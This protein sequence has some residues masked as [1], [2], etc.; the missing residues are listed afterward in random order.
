MQSVSGLE[1]FLTIS[2]QEYGSLTGRESSDVW[3]DHTPNNIDYMIPLAKIF[4]NAKFIHLIR[5]GRGVAASVIELPWGPN[6]ITAAADW[7]I[8]RLAVGLAA[9]QYFGP[10][11]VLRVKYEDLILNTT[12]TL[13]VIV[14]FLGLEKMNN[15][16]KS[17]NRMILP[18]FTQEQHK[19]VNEPPDQSRVTSWKVSL[20]ARQIEIFELKALSI[21]QYLGYHRYTEGV[22]RPIS[23]GESIRMRFHNLTRN[24]KK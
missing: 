3:V 22:I 17:I 21:M 11:R 24:Y 14:Q 1:Q 15:I 6:I 5:D 2:V 4:Q 16:E 19:L 20:T 23:T 13:N 9:E 18:D 8:Q 12:E 10:S 7:W